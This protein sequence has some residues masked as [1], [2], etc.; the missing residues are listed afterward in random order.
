MFHRRI[1]SSR[2]YCG[3]ANNLKVEPIEVVAL[4]VMAI[5]V[6]LTLGYLSSDVGSQ[7][8][9]VQGG[10]VTLIMLIAMAIVCIIFVVRR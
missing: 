9:T 10:V 5:G 8:G 3:E 6:I 7:W 2:S 1:R 4:M